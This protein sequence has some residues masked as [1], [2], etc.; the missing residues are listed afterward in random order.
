MF[1]HMV[2]VWKKFKMCIWVE[3]QAISES[4][5]CWT[6]QGDS[7]N[8]HKH[9]LSVTWSVRLPVCLWKIML[10]CAFKW[11]LMQNLFS[12][13]N[14]V[15]KYSWTLSVCESVYGKNVKICKFLWKVLKGPIPKVIL[16][17]NLP[18]PWFP[19]LELTVFVHR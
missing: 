16:E 3:F 15:Q 18:G 1:D 5:S 19:K 2:C 6:Y 4:K 17:H 10:N 14:R 9:C 7:K 13:L 8:N 11:I 12:L